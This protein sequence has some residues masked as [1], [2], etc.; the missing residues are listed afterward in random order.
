[1]GHPR[2][3]TDRVPRVPRGEQKR[4]PSSVRRLIYQ[5]TWPPAD[6][7]HHEAIAIKGKMKVVVVGGAGYL[8]RPLVRLLCGHADTV[9]ASQRRGEG[10]DQ[11]IDIRRP[12]EIYRLLARVRPDVVVVTAYML[13]RATSADPMRAVE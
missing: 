9:S 2:H 7:S 1:M 6:R 8:G 13:E 3:V 4:R 10:V 12:E 5:L 11:Q